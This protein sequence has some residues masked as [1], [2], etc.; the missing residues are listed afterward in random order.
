MASI[1]TKN[2]E[3]TDKDTK[4]SEQDSMREENT[5]DQSYFDFQA[6]L[7]SLKAML[8]VVLMFLAMISYH[9]HRKYSI[10]QVLPESPQMS[11]ERMAKVKSVHSEFIKLS[12]SPS[13]EAN[14]ARRSLLRISK[15]VA[16]VKERLNKIYDRLG[17]DIK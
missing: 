15:G 7:R 5:V 11:A 13:K 8:P 4:T 1:I 12:L 2:L 14:Q 9:L 17:E 3:S 10:P 16:R 6:F